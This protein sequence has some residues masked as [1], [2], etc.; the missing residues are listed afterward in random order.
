MNNTLSEKHTKVLK[1]I[2]AYGGYK[3][4]ARELNCTEQSVKNSAKAI[5]TKLEVD[6]M[7][8]AIHKATKEGWI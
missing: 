3:H 7:P 8:Q 6:T 4:V 2:V 1:Y 5:K